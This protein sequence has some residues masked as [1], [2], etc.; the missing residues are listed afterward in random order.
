V[1]LTKLGRDVLDGKADRVEAAP[2]DRWL[3]GTRV[4]GTWRWDAAT[5]RLLR[6]GRSSG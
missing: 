1:T 3:G 5:R 2:P 4:D 6:P